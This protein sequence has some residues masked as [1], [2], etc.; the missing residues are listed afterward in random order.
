MATPG[1]SVLES[2]HV[3]FGGHFGMRNRSKNPNWSDAYSWELNG[4]KCR[5][6]L[7]NLVNHLEI[8]K[9]QAK[10]LIW[11]ID[12]VIGKHVPDAARE[13]LKAEMKAM[14]RDPQRLSDRAVSEF[15]K[16]VNGC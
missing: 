3:N 13:H 16:I 7:Q 14:K 9:E 12:N 5:P 10:L 11:M 4:K 1:I 8:K 2:L 6:F 15:H